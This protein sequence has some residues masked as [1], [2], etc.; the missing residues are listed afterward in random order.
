[1]QCTQKIARHSLN[2]KKLLKQK[3][4]IFFTLWKFIW[5]KSTS[6]KCSEYYSFFLLLALYQFFGLKN[7]L[8]PH[9]VTTLSQNW[10]SSSSFS[11]STF[12]V[13]LQTYRINHD[14]K[15]QLFC[16]APPPYFTEWY[17]NSDKTG[18]Y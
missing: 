3:N 13:V 7:V 5:E 14:I 9:L 6:V 11:I 4:E 12:A 8:C 15:G 16:C 10:Y 17:C 2:K 1:M 18:F